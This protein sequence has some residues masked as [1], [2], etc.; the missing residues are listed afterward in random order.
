MSDIYV[1]GG[2]LSGL[3][4]AWELA[5]AGAKVTVLEKQAIGQESSWAGGGIL[6]PLYPWRYPDPVNILACWSQD[7][8]QQF[9][10]Q[11]SLQ[12]G[13]DPQWQPSGMLMLSMA[14]EI[15]RASTWAQQFKREMVPVVGKPLLGLES[16]ISPAV[17]S[18]P[19]LW[20][21]QVAQVRNPRL[22]KALR[23]QLEKLGVNLSEYVEVSGFYTD[24]GKLTGLR[25]AGH[26]RIN[27]NSVVVASGAWSGGLL[28]DLGIRTE[29]VPVRGQML[30]FKAEPGVL[31]RIV[32]YQGRYLIPR[33]DGRILVGSTMEHV[34]FDKS[35]TNQSLEELHSVALKVVPELANYPIERHWAGLRPGS[36]EGIPLISAHPAVDGLFVNAGHFRNGVVM[37]LCSA[38][39]AA[40]L[41]L[42]R[43]PVVDPLPYQIKA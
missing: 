21:P 33:Q 20:M 24:A 1:I 7:H 4:T 25:L 27:A 5:N 11:L 12:S 30:L 28:G 22:L 41:I 18:E 37:G 17:S 13:I 6:S 40:D 26:G 9:C 36:P 35:T 3:L 14:E 43:Q 32:L 31:S 34:G 39:L 10:E 23:V 19:A 38:R 15:S 2:G 29:I 8:Y 16:G 42:D